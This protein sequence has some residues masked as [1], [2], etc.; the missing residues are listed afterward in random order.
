[1]LKELLLFTGINVWPKHI[2]G[3]WLVFIKWIADLSFISGAVTT[4]QKNESQDRMI[5]SNEITATLSFCMISL[6]LYF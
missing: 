6:L 2:A 5:T 4:N 1:M 3:Q